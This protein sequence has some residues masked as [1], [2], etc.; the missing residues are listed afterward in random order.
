MARSGAGREEDAVSLD[1]LRAAWR[2]QRASGRGHFQRTWA[3]GLKSSGRDKI[4]A[5][6]LSS[7]KTVKNGQTCKLCRASDKQPRLRTA[8]L[9]KREA[10]SEI[11]LTP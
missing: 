8:F 1:M 3:A 4:S 11:A 10:V 2:C 6:L 9:S 5:G 7:S